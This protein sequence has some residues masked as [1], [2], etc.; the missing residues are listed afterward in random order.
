MD[1]ISTNSYHASCASD[2]EESQ[3]L[4]RVRILRW[5]RLGLAILIAGLSIALVACEAVPFHH[6]RRTSAYEK[7]GLYLWPLNLDIRPAI[8]LISCGSILAFSN[9]TYITTALLPSPRAHIHKINLLAATT[10][11][12]G[13]LAALAA[14]VFAIHLPGSHPPSG[15][16]GVETLHSWTCK[17]KVKHGLLRHNL[18]EIVSSPPRHFG[19]DCAA[20]KAAFVLMACV[21]GLEILMGAVAAIGAWLARS[22]EK[23]RAESEVLVKVES[24]AKYPGT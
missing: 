16:S 17:W 13:F 15:F 10:A 5:V 14:V 12:I 9:I 11:L 7:V 4:K 3:Y 20:T 6:Y 1:T 24:V 21:L 8:A 2:E 18:D 19:R 23:K 22:V